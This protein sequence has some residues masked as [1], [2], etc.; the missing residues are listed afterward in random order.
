MN[1]KG[2]LKKLQHYKNNADYTLLIWKSGRTAIKLMSIS[3]SVSD[4][5]F[6]NYDITRGITVKGTKDILQENDVFQA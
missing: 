6:L 2:Y 5:F 4:F 1:Q 3:T